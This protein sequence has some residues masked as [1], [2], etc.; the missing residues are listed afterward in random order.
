LAIG[1]TGTDGS[2]RKSVLVPE[3]GDYRFVF[4]VGTYDKTGGL[5]AGADMTIDNIRAENAYSIEDDAVQALLRAVHYENSSDTATADKILTATVNNYDKTSVTTDDALINMS[6]FNITGD[7]GPYMV[8]PS[9]NLVTNPEA[10]VTN[11]SASALTSK[12]ELLQQ[13]IDALRTQAGSKVSAIESAIDSATDLRSQFALASGTLSDIN[14]SLETVHA[15]KRQ[16][17]QDVAAAMM[18]QANKSQDGMLSLVAEVEVK[19]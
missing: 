17:Q 16:I 15:A 12:V 18:A 14:F 10:G 13:K 9:E 19:S 8:A 3:T 7:G 4:I 5:A 11:G 2:G 1:D 6:G